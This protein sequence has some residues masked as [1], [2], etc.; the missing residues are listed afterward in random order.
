MTL[1]RRLSEFFAAF[2]SFSE[3]APREAGWREE[4]ADILEDLRALAGDYRALSG[5]IPGVVALAA[6]LEQAADEGGR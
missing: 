6:R 1:L 5:E 4:M 2:A 3:L